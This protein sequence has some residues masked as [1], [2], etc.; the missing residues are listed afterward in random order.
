MHCCRSLRNDSGV[1]PGQTEHEID[2]QRQIGAAE[3][4]GEL[5]VLLGLDVRAP[6]GGE[7]VVVHRLQRQHALGDDAGA[8]R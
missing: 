1:E 8:R 7:R 4:A 3:L 6:D 2:E 5:V